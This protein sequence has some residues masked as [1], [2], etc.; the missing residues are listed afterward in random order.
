MQ[1]VKPKD[2][3]DEAKYLRMMVYGAPGVGKTW[4]L[5][6]ACLKSSLA[7]TSPVLFLEYRSQIQSLHSNPKYVEA[8]ED[9]RLKIVR[10][11]SYDE[12]SHVYSWM[13]NPDD[14]KELQSLFPDTGGHCRTLCLDSVTELQRSEVLRWAGNPL[15]KFLRELEY[16][17]PRS[18]GNLLNQFALLGRMYYDAS[19]PMHVV[20]G[21]LEQT[22]YNPEGTQ[23]RG[24]K[25]ALQGQSQDILPSYALTLMRLLRSPDKEHFNVGVTTAVKAHSKEQTGKIPGVLQSPTIPKL[26]YLLEGGE[27]KDIR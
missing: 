19:I 27:L 12:L 16:P 10:L 9:G 4:F 24:Y 2:L 14:C 13:R 21:A 17:S 11:S 3:T 7:D 20:F 8:M 25:V 23:V 5:A 6:S 1:L 26:A 18:W 22:N 15:N